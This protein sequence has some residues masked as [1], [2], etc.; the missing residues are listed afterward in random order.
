MI[1]SQNTQI[2]VVDGRN[3]AIVGFS[4]LNWPMF[5]RSIDDKQLYD[6]NKDN[7]NNQINQ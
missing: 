3:N 6:P 5:M 4:A 7:K 1:D 2:E